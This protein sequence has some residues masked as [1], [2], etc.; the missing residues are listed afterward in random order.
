MISRRSK[1]REDGSWQEY[2]AK[3]RQTERYQNYMREYMR[4]YKSTPE[5]KAAYKLRKAARE[6]KKKEKCIL[7]ID[8]P[9]N[10]HGKQ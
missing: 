10:A 1:K 6:A 3:V 9:F 5:W 7:L 8:Q 2:R 4:K